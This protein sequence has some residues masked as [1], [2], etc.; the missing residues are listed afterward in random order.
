MGL[1]G[2]HQYLDRVEEL[3]E[4]RRFEEALS[5]CHHILRQN[6]RHV[7]TY[8]LI[9]RVLLEQHV[10]DDAL[11]VFQRVLSVDPEDL[12]SHA[13]TAIAYRDNGELPLAIWHMERAAEIDAYNSAVQEELNGLYENIEDRADEGKELSQAALARLNFHGGLYQ[14]A[15]DKLQTLL[16]QNP[17][18]H[19]LQVLLAE[20]LYSDDRLS[21]AAN[22]SAKILNSLPDCIKANAILGLYHVKAGENEIATK[23]AN[24]LLP[25][26]LPELITLDDNSLAGQ[27][28]STIDSHLI[29]ERML[30]EELDYRKQVESSAKLE[31]S[32]IP[33]SKYLQ[34][35]TGIPTWL[36]DASAEDLTIQQ[37]SI[38]Q[39]S[40]IEDVDDVFDWLRTIAEE[41]GNIVEANEQ[42]SDEG[43]Q[44]SFGQ[45]EDGDVTEDELYKSVATDARVTLSQ[46][47]EYLSQEKEAANYPRPIGITD[48]NEA[49]LQGEDDE[50]PEWLEEV[51]GFT[52]SLKSDDPNCLVKIS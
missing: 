10:V 5:H 52:D 38:E 46:Q 20:V 29:P 7:D 13:G 42:K 50:F 37:D 43:L 18:R 41:E 39:V 14:Q 44:S 6:P 51:I 8:R 26:M 17:D 40:E 24:K 28:F 9:G 27:F 32:A 36:N 3:L 33:G 48:Q 1:V 21:A 4:A 22:M 15:K 30:V 45:Q 35:V 12:V 31:G 47:L 49:I 16:T 11:D 34:A 19:D 2:L 23:Y 25:L